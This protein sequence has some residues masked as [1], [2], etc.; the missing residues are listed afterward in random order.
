MRFCDLFISY[1]IALKGLKS[2]IP[3]TNLPLYRKIA[4]IFLFS[5]AII[6]SIFYILKMNIAV[7][8]T[9]STIIILI[10]IFILIDSRKGNLEIMLKNHYLPY[11]KKRM[12]MIIKILQQYQIDIHNTSSINLLIEEAQTAQTQC[13]YF[14][15]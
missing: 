3:F 11:S 12:D 1:K 7:L 5:M 2:T 10:A 15:L 13:N 6:L 8:I 4:I 14:Y 9:F